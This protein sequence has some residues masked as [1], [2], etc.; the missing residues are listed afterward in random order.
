VAEEQYGMPKKRTTAQQRAREL[1]SADG[2]TLTYGQSLQQVRRRHR[3]VPRPGEA[4]TTLAEL[5]TAS[6]LSVTWQKRFVHHLA[7]SDEDGWPAEHHARELYEELHIA[8]GAHLPGPDGPALPRELRYFPLSPVKRGLQTGDTAELACA[9]VETFAGPLRHLLRHPYGSPASVDDLV[10]RIRRAPTRA[11]RHQLTIHTPEDLYFD[12]VHY[13]RP[14]GTPLTYGFFRTT[15]VH[16]RDD[17]ARALL[18]HALGGAEPTSLAA[19]TACQANGLLSALDADHSSHVPAYRSERTFCI[20]GEC[21]GSGLRALPARAFAEE[22]LSAET[23]T[24]SEA[25]PW[26]MARSSI[27]TWAS[28]RLLPQP[29]PSSGCRDGLQAGY[30]AAVAAALLSA[31]FTVD[32]GKEPAGYELDFDDRGD[33]GGHFYVGG[34]PCLTHEFGASRLLMFWYSDRGWTITGFGEVLALL[35]GQTVPEPETVVQALQARPPA[36][37]SS[38]PLLVPRD[39]DVYAKVLTYLPQ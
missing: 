24:T 26:V 7:A 29:G 5:A 21:R 22:F 23:G 2:S 19:C 18:A 38:R 4:R 3:D 25:E 6:D 12:D 16:G 34:H 37:D 39:V 28:P 33:L 13:P 35:P 9:L 36:D 27:I 30:I 15:D 31:G 20:C 32:A 11:P 1:Q 14:W 8:V 10:Y 17:L